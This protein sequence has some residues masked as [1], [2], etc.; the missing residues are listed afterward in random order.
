MKCPY[1]NKEAKWCNNKEV[2]GKQYGRSY[3][4]YWCKDCD[5]YVG[6]HN[7][8][9][10]AL[11]IMANRKLRRLRMECHKIFDLYWSDKNSRRAAY[12]WLCHVM[13]IHP[14]LA[15]IGKFNEE[16]C[17]KLLSIL[18]EELKNS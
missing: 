18:R 17:E 10:R 14:Q 4:C 9:R 1:C 16:Q 7:N 5:A 2:Y 6:C 13:K 15:H 3:M 8:T 12:D 11:G